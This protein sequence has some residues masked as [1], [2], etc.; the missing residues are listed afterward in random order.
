[1]FSNNTS[2]HTATCFTPQFLMFGE[3][4]R[5]PSEVFIGILKLEQNPLGYSFRCYQRLSLAYNAAR[6]A[7]ACAQ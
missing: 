1:M 7:T 4:A 3:E 5:I 2:V 6:E